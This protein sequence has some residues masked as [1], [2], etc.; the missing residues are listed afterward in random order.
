MERR[1]IE[2]STTLYNII[3]ESNGFYINSVDP[4]CR[5]RMNI[6]FRVMNNEALENKFVS[7]AKAVG[8]LGLKGHRSVGGI[9]ASVFNAV[10]PAHVNRLAD[11]MK[12]F[13]VAN[14]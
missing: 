12:K 14:S 9:R 8:L 11:F 4:D 3:D 7:E 1:A 5:S 10:L 2:K 6:V 13:Q